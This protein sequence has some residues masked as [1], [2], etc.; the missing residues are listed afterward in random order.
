M[1]EARQRDT[2]LARRLDEVQASLANG[3]GAGGFTSG[4]D[5]TELE[6]ALDPLERLADP[7]GFPRVQ[8]SMTRLR[9][10]LGQLRVPAAQTDGW[11]ALERGLLAHLGVAP[12]PKSLRALLEELA[13]SLRAEASAALGRMSYEDARDA[14][15]GSHLLDAGS[16][17]EVTGSPVRSSAPPERA[18]LCAVL[19]A[20]RYPRS[21]PGVAALVGLADDVTLAIW[22][23]EIDGDGRDPYRVVSAHPLLSQLPPE[24]EGPLMRTVATRPLLPLGVAL[25]ARLLTTPGPEERSSRVARWLAFGDAPL[26]VVAHELGLPVP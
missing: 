22:A 6:S 26:D 7:M 2:W 4:V 15:A 9:V 10:A 5:V 11:E 3:A 14:R 8:A 18:P 23:I 1:D 13:A 16:C 24:L 21:A 20:L 12:E 25:M 17:G 19:Q